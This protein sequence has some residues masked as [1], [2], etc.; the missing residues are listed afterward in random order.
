[1]TEWQTGLFLRT[2]T[3]WFIQMRTVLFMGG[4]MLTCSMVAHLMI[5]QNGPI[6]AEPGWKLWGPIE[7]LLFDWVWTSQDSVR[8]VRSD[9]VWGQHGASQLVCADLPGCC[10]FQSPMDRACSVC[11]VQCMLVLSVCQGT[12]CKWEGGLGR[13]DFWSHW[14]PW[15]HTLTNMR[16]AV[17]LW[18]TGQFRIWRLW[19]W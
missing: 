6:T 9:S 12:C 15:R 3:I 16:Q 13:K 10:M 2:L 5:L 8:L 11:A 4:E 1:M 14:K 17:F 19:K 7:Q 18:A